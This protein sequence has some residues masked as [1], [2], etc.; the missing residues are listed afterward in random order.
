MLS[1]TTCQWMQDNGFDPQAP[2]QTGKYQ[3]SPLILACRQGEIAIAGDL[4]DAGV[5]IHLRNMD[6]TDAL[7]A[8]VVSDSFTLA[9]ALL[10][11]GADIDNQ[12]DNGATALMYASSSGKTAW[13]EFFL[14]H[15]ADTSKRSLDDFS[16]LELASNRDCL[17]LLR[18][19]G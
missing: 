17:R 12:N 2:N 18:A 16:A 5:D 11:N 3:D 19:C 1:V 6:G 7:W 4:L 15:G 10:R 14:A 9:D 13:V 8:C